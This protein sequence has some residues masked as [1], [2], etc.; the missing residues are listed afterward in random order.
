VTDYYPEVILSLRELL[1]A[2]A[3]FTK[4]SGAKASISSLRFA[5]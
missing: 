1:L 4:A 5:I 2:M 3:F